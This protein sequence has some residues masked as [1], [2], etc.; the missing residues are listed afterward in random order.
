MT[1]V[2]GFVKGEEVTYSL[3]KAPNWL[4]NVSRQTVMLF[5]LS[6]K[7]KEL[8]NSLLFASDWLTI[9]VC[10]IWF[11]K[12]RFIEKSNNTTS[13]ISLL[14]QILAQVSVCV[15]F[16]YLL[17]TWTRNGHRQSLTIVNRLA[18]TFKLLRN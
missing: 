1:I 9:S 6:Y 17:K 8:T 16:C 4:Q 3:F 14:L 15:H 5:L 10:V 12:E 11:D 7:D 2:Q 18:F 13:K